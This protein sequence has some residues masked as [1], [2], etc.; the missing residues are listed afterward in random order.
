[1]EVELMIAGA[2]ESMLIWFTGYFCSGDLDLGG[3]EHVGE[4]G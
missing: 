3:V 1:M 2:G 4:A